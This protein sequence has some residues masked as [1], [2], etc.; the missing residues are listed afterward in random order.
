MDDQS[1]IRNE[2]IEFT[3]IDSSCLGGRT[4]RNYHSFEKGQAMITMI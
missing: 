1:Y 4:R 3:N 2:Q